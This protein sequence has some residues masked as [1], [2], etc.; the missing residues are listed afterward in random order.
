MTSQ[1]MRIIRRRA[2]S[3]VLAC[4]GLLVALLVIPAVL[5]AGGVQA[6]TFS[7]E[8][9]T[10]R[11]DSSVRVGKLD[12]RDGRV[13]IETMEFPDGFFLLDMTAARQ[14][15]YFVRPAVRVYMDARQS[16]RLTQWFV[17]VDPEAPCLQWQAMARVSGKEGEGEWRCER[18]GEE[19]IEGHETNAFRVS[20]PSGQAYSGWVDRERRF[21]L[22]I[23]TADGDLIMLEEIRDE[24]LPAAS[25]ELPAEYGKFN[26]EALI[27]RIKQ[28]DVWVA[29]PDDDKPNDRPNEKSKPP[30]P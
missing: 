13:R 21:P 1:A 11:D 19:T 20:T 5:W 8:I 24:A 7:S 22:R 15:A 3:S 10:R 30:R 17:P 23:K 6:Q 4:R 14:T 27:E 16:S 26:P 12:V 29:K 18:L 9:V 2:A 25:F 28:S